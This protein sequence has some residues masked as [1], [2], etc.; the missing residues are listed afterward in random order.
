M[1]WTRPNLV[2]PRFHYTRTWWK[3]RFTWF[4]A[5]ALGR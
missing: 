2:K 3:P 4:S 5:G 1:L